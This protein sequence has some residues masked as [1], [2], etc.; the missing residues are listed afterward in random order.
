MSGGR[1][2]IS[3]LLGILL[4]AVCLGVGSYLSYQRRFTRVGNDR[5]EKTIEVLDLSG[6]PLENVEQL[7]AFTGLKTMDLRGTGLAPEDYDRV[8]AWFPEAEVYWDIP[9]QG[10][11]FP[12]DTREL[13]I[14]A[15]TEAD[16]EMLPYFTELKRISGEDCP[17]YPILHELRQQR[18]DLEIRYRV[19]VNGEAFSWDLKEISLPGADVEALFEALTFLTELENVA[20]R[21]P[22]APMERISALAEAFPEVSFSWELEVG[23]ITVNEKTETLDL[24]GIPMTVEE[25]DAVIPYLPKLTFVDMTDCGISNEEMD[26]LNNRYDDIQIVWTVVLGSWYRIRTDV[27]SFMSVRDGFYPK[28]N[29]LYNLRYCHDMIAIDVGHREIT[30]IDFVAHMPHLRYFLMCE[31]KVRD[32]TPLTGLTELIYLEIFLNEIKDLSPLATLTALE[33]LNL[34]YVG[35]DP[36]VIARMTWL[37][38]LWWNYG[39]GS[40][41]MLQAALPDC[42]FNYTSY[43]STGGGWREL[44]NYYAQRDI[45]GMYY[46]KG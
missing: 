20:L 31:T 25:M 11:T 18:P 43:S 17:D 2:V 5:Y 28:G 10:K 41:A 26:A 32:L 7:Q 34:Y 45:F 12:M 40:R 39:A 3:C 23:G 4:A 22:L 27:T 29:D 19:P 13:K 8:R 15:L 44:P 21:P 30:N 1:R 6:T 14:T 24:T 46:M 33:D 42:K 9:F 35:G 36:E 38:N 16:L 37:K